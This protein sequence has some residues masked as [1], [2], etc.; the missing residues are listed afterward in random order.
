LKSHILVLVV[1]PAVRCSPKS[2]QI[3]LKMVGAEVVGSGV[4]AVGSVVGSGVG[5]A[6]R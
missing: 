5:E 3:A 6:A 2:G 4:G 1:S